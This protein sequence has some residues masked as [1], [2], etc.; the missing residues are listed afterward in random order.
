VSG[1][2]IMISKT[3]RM[4]SRQLLIARIAYAST[5]FSPLPCHAW[6]VYM[7]TNAYRVEVEV[8]VDGRASAPPPGPPPLRHQRAPQPRGS[9]IIL[10]SIAVNGLAF[11]PC[12]TG[13]VNASQPK[14]EMLH[15]GF[16]S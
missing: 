10:A 13:N 5:S 12:V 6:H 8:G 2:D 3:L 15:F 11:T 16:I 7:V 1:K 4:A 14:C 9:Y